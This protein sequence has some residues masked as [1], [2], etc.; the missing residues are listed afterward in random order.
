MSFRIKVGIQEFL[1]EVLLKF[2]KV[3]NYREKGKELDNNIEE[4]GAEGQDLRLS[5][6][7]MFPGF[8]REG[9]MSAMVSALTHV[10]CGDQNNDDFSVL[11]QNMNH[12]AF[13]QGDGIDINPF[14]SA[15]TSSTSLSYGDSSAL[16]RRREDGGF[17]HNSSSAF[18]PNKHQVVIDAELDR[19]GHSSI[20]ATVIGRV[21]K[22]LDAKT[23]PRT[24][25]ECS[26]NWTNTITT[27]RSQISEPIYEYRID[28]NNVKNE[29]QPKR[30][31]RGVR[32]RPWGK[33]A[34]EI[35]DPFKATRVW[36]GT[37]ET[38]E[39]A[40]KAYD[41]AALR[42]RGNKAKLNFPENVRLKQQSLVNPIQSSIDPRVQGESLQG[43]NSSKKFYGQNF[44]VRLYDQ[45]TMSSPNEMASLQTSMSPSAS[46][47]SSTTTIASSFSSPQTTS[48]PPVYTTDFPAWS[49]GFNSSPSG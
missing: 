45:I 29:D 27:E 9:E 16:K 5:M 17:F 15:T 44:P 28:N 43:S 10:I 25:L 23:D 1:H 18:P 11:N 4:E 22:P 36:L 32:Q 2:E 7:M 41:Q 14:V 8:H 40:A 30:K 39:D 49:S 13:D 26:S 31:Y 47:S 24:R 33:W 38:A 20:P 34:A 3:A 6:P 46:Y 21:L 19:E 42:F 48:I 37:F 35:R 12:S